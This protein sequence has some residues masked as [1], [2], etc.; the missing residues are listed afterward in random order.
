MLWLAGHREGAIN[1]HRI[2]EVLFDYGTNMSP[3]MFSPPRTGIALRARKMGFFKFQWIGLMRRSIKL[4]SL[5]GSANIVLGCDTIRLKNLIYLLLSKAVKI[6][7]EGVSKCSCPIYWATVPDKS[8]NYGNFG[9]NG[10]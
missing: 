10:Y 3:Y 9:V 1:A 7:L 2:V 4:L 8:G 5:T 6:T